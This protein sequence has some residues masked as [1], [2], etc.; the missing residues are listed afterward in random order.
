V[1]K[2][3]GLHMAVHKKSKQREQTERPILTKSAHPKK[4]VTDGD[5]DA[6][7]GKQKVFQI[8]QQISL[9][10]G[11]WYLSRIVSKLDF[12]DKSVLKLSRIAFGIYIMVVQ[13]IYAFLTKTILSRDNNNSFVEAL[14]KSQSFSTMTGLFNEVDSTH[15]PNKKQL[16]S[17][18]DYDLSEAK[19]VF[20]S[21]LPIEL[22]GV[23]FLHLV[24]HWNT[25]LLLAP[26]SLLSS[27][28]QSPVVQVNL[29][30]LHPV[31]SLKRPFAGMLDSLVSSLNEQSGLSTDN[32]AYTVDG[33]NDLPGGAVDGSGNDMSESECLVEDEDIQEGKE[34]EE[35]EEE[36]EENGEEKEVEEESEVH[37]NYDE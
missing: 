24:F 13:I 31:G 19:K 5:A 18:R 10:L 29:L 3:I 27:K 4:L 36:E 34:E 8:V 11:S 22:L 16:I 26:L 17:V 23:L 1:G 2:F 15:D 14:D 30:G 25:P 35:E 33:S 7:L 20:I 32:E 21:S 6:T 37:G 28:L 12:T 9:S